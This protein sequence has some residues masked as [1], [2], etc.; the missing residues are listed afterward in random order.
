[1]FILSILIIFV[2][3]DF[4]RN[5]PPFRL[6]SEEAP[7]LVPQNTGQASLGAGAITHAQDHTRQ[8]AERRDSE[9]S[10]R[11]WFRILLWRSRTSANSWLGALWARPPIPSARP[12]LR[13]GQ[14]VSVSPT[15]RRSCRGSIPPPV[16]CP[17]AAFPP[18]YHIHT[19]HAARFPVF[20]T[21][22]PAAPSRQSG[23]SHTGS[24]RP[25]A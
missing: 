3:I 11:P 7:R 22:A 20:F 8:K 25:A 10:R 12:Y 5:S 14:G 2:K 13:S 17:P 6:Y 1:M 16:R 19:Y 15:F 24:A 18:R 23:F 9:L 4:G 21:A